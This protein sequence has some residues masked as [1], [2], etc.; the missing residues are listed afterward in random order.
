MHAG[1]ASLQRCFV[2]F[3]NNDAT[4]IAA[5]QLGSVGCGLQKHARSF[6][7]GGGAEAPTA[8]PSGINIAAAWYSADVC[9][10]LILNLLAVSFF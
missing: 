2:C 10:V 5:S 1:L 3:C 9:A 7:L 4:S 8:V 6:H